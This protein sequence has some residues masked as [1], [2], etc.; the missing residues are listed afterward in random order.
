MM[1]VTKAALVARLREAHVSERREGAQ[2]SVRV[3]DVELVRLRQ[4][5]ARVGLALCAVAAPAVR[6]DGLR[7]APATRR[8]G[9]ER[10]R[11]TAGPW[12]EGASG[13][14]EHGIV[15]YEGRKLD[16]G[17]RKELAILPLPPQDLVCGQHTPKLGLEVEAFVAAGRAAGARVGPELPVAMRDLPDYRVQRERSGCRVRVVRVLQRCESAPSCYEAWR[18]G[19]AAL[20]RRCGGRRG[21]AE[22]E[23]SGDRWVGL[24]RAVARRGRALRE[25]GRGYVRNSEEAADEGS[26]EAYERTSDEIFLLDQLGEGEALVVDLVDQRVDARFDG[27]VK[28]LVGGENGAKVLV[29]GRQLGKPQSHVDDLANVI[30]TEGREPVDEV[31]CTPPGRGPDRVAG[32]RVDVAQRVVELRQG[33]CGGVDD[34]REVRRLGVVICIAHGPAPEPIQPKLDFCDSERRVAKDSAVILLKV[35]ENELLAK[36]GRDSR[37]SLASLVSEIT[38]ANV[39]LNRVL[40]RLDGEGDESRAGLPKEQQDGRLRHRTDILLRNVLAEG[41]R[42]LPCDGHDSA[43]DAELLKL[44]RR[45]R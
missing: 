22:V 13:G 27:R 7:R 8:G 32:V 15:R 9:R 16:R 44:F 42:G 4:A 39:V 45:G 11:D 33:A 3:R 5:G 18:R 41:R 21:G 20:A 14:A 40:G 36:A 34:E 30:R 23:R 25:S 19:R 17:L 31:D 6:V 28:L 1:C 24:G 43:G 2:H 26:E 37:A 35:V 29:H 38:Q 10:L 12:A